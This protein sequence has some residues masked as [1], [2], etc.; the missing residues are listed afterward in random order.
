M[1]TNREYAEQNKEFQ[2]LCEAVGT[3]PTKCQ[4]S[5]FQRNRGIVWMYTQKMN[6]DGCKRHGEIKKGRWD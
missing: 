6:I 4:A 1:M 3:V 5:K 2:R